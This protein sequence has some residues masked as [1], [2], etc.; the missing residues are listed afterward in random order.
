MPAIIL[1][2]AL[3]AAGFLKTSAQSETSRL[4]SVIHKEDQFILSLPEGFCDETQKAFVALTLDTLNKFADEAAK[5]LLN[6][7]LVFRACEATDLLPWG[8]LS[9]GASNDKTVTQSMYNKQLAFLLGETDILDRLQDYIVDSTKEIWS[10]EFALEL[11][12]EGL[13]SKL[14]WADDTV[15]IFISKSTLTNS[16]EEYLGNEITVTASTLIHHRSVDYFLFID[17]TIE[18]AELED[19]I[20]SLRENAKLIHRLNPP[21]AES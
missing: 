14:V 16:G 12:A 9:I 18:Q 1:F 8:Y 6:P 20:K 13:E 19:L 17:E 21:K 15:I 4:I 11:A 7:K 10:K 2:L 3:I 5:G